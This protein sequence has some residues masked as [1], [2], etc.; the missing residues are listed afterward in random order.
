MLQ[1]SQAPL[2][3][4]P[5]PARGQSR[6][7]PGAHP[8]RRAGLPLAA[9]TPSGGAGLR[10]CLSSRRRQRRGG[11]AGLPSV[12]PPPP[13]AAVAAPS[14]PIAGRRD[15]ARRCGPR[16]RGRPS[17]ARAQERSQQGL[18]RR[19]TARAAATGGFLRAGSTCAPPEPSPAANRPRGSPGTGGSSCQRRP[20]GCSSSVPAGH[21]GG[22]GLRAQLKLVE[23]N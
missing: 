16:R 9:T 13:G 15:A 22:C 21:C 17:T 3:S 12:R 6:S 5:R 19:K 23:Q 18:S 1:R 2:L 8:H 11:H 14:R 7:R 10:R 20:R 4:S